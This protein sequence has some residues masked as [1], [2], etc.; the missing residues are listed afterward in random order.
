MKINTRQLRRIIQEEIGRLHE[1]EGDSVESY[2]ARNI[3]T[4][5]LVTLMDNADAVAGGH[6]AVH[7]YLVG[8]LDA[9]LKDATEMTGPDRVF[10]GGVEV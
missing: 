8:L 1:M 10:V 5:R 3:D 7:A 2:V 4:G 6:R 9:A